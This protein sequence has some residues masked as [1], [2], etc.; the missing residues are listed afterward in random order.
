MGE[1][2]DI[3]RARLEAEKQRDSGAIEALKRREKEL[4]EEIAIKQLRSTGQ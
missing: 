3:Q 2:H 1:L 4:T